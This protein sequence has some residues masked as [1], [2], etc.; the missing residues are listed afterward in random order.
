MCLQILS[1]SPTARTAGSCTHSMLYSYVIFSGTLPSSQ[2]IFRSHTSPFPSNAGDPS[3]HLA[4]PRVVGSRSKGLS[5]LLYSSFY[6]AYHS[7]AYR[8]VKAS[9]LWGIAV[10]YVS[11]LWGGFA[12]YCSCSC[13]STMPC[14]RGFIARPTL[15]VLLRMTHH[16]LRVW[17]PIK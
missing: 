6:A 10:Y 13:H 1:I 12:S 4:A 15:L 7:A 8:C 5:Y 2:L 16:T 11:G 9:V 3:L 14:L 17:Y